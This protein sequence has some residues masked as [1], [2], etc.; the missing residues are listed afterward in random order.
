MHAR[1]IGKGCKRGGVERRNARGLRLA[2]QQLPCHAV[3][4]HREA[5]AFWQNNLLVVC[6]PAVQAA[7][8]RCYGIEMLCEACLQRR[9]CC[10]TY[11]QSSLAILASEG[12][13]CIEHCSPSNLAAGEPPGV[14]DPHLHSQI[15]QLE[16][17]FRLEEWCWPPAA[18][19]AGHVLHCVRHA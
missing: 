19:C 5:V 13:S 16:L 15:A 2:L 3:L 14:L 18:T 1:Q 9:P 7:A 17:A 4:V 11:R 10:N 8:L 12:D 6:V